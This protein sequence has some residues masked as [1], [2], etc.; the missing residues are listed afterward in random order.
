MELGPILTKLGPILEL[1]FAT[2]DKKEGPTDLPV[3]A[4]CPVTNLQL[5]AGV[6]HRHSIGVGVP[7]VKGTQRDAACGFHSLRINLAKPMQAACSRTQRCQAKHRLTGL[8]RLDLFHLAHVGVTGRPTA[9]CCPRRRWLA[10]AAQ[11]HVETI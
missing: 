9:D 8:F 2:L 6:Q 5:I 11:T 4:I 1:G 7:I 3:A 10:A